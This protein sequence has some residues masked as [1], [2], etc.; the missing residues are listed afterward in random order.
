[1]RPDCKCPSFRC[2]VWP[3][4]LAAAGLPEARFHDLRL[5]GAASEPGEVLEDAASAPVRRKVCETGE[6]L[7]LG[8]TLRWTD[9]IP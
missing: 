9:D 4:A 5:A 8:L 3:N 6:G 1:M 2:G 7:G